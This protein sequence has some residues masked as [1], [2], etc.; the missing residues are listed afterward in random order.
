MAS[1]LASAAVF[2]FAAV[3][4][5]AVRAET[6]RDEQPDCDE[7]RASAATMGPRNR[8]AEV[9]TFGVAATQTLRRLEDRSSADGSILASASHFAYDTRIIFSGRS[10]GFGFIGGGSAGFEGGL[11]G[12]LAF[13][14]RL[15]FAKTHG[16]FARVAVEGFLMGNDTFFASLLELPKGEFGYQLL[17]PE[18]LFEFAATAG[19]VL[20]G[21]YNVDDVPAR[22]L[23]GLLQV[24]GHAAFGLRHVHLELAIERFDSSD[25]ELDPLTEVGGSL[26]GLPLVFAVCAHVRHLAAGANAPA[27]DMRIAYLGI[28]VGVIT[29]SDPRRHANR[30]GVRTRSYVAPTFG[31]G[32]SPGAQ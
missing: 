8:V 30:N 16:P 9:Q 7:R 28:H 25:Y 18:V 31:Y 27:P 10:T 21:R 26:C 2:A 3:V 6:C 12:E 15:P 22:P 4:A 23:G 17:N 19:P 11:G 14:L 29:A 20:A 1:V 24:G 5:P 13:G 32:G